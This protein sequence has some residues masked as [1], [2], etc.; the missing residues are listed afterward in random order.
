MAH[1]VVGL[2]N[3]GP[4]FSETRHNVGQRVVDALAHRLRVLWRREGGG[5]VAHAVWQGDALHLVKPHAFMNVTGPAVAVALHR[6]DLAPG[7]LI[8]VYDDIDLPLGTVRIRMKG[9]HGGHNGV[10]SVIE[11]L[12]TSDVKR[13]KVGIGRPEEK[14]DVVD[15]VLAVFDPDERPVIDAAV[16]NAVERVLSLVSEAVGGV[17]GESGG[18]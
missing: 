6:L 7:D 11:A 14:R 3:P 5:H 16:T 4:E 9:S 18:A 1:V 2:G 15:H 12:G 8:L 13:V 17:A 10:R